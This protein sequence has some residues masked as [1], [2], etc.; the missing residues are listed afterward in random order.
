M[1]KFEVHPVAA[2]FPMLANDE[3]VELANDIGERGLLQPIVLDADGRV[4]DGRNRLAACEMAAVEPTF[5]TYEGDDPAGYALSVNIAR[6]HMTASQRAI[7]VARAV[8]VEGTTIRDGSTRFKLNHARIGQANTILDFAPA[9]ADAVASGAMPF[10]DAYKEARG[11]K[12]KA[13]S[14]ESQLADLRAEDT[15]LADRVVEGELS[16]P[17]AWAER[18]ERVKRQ[19]VDR[20]TGRDAADRLVTSVNTA[21][22]SIAIAAQLGETGLVTAEM[23]AALQGSVDLLK[24]IL[25]EGK[26]S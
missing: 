12:A 9:L 10:D 1:S 21:A 15:E 19:K 4:L 22:S 8:R 23:V 17:G 7:T 11:N 5:I 20:Q 18:K 24:K 6:R 26:A 25:D 16:L 3:L 13:D 2:L 14:F